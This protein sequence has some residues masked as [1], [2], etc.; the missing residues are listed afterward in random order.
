MIF[1]P[2][3][4]MTERTRVFTRVMPSW[5]V[6]GRRMKIVSYSRCVPGSSLIDKAIAQSSSRVSKPSNTCR[7]RGDRPGQNRLGS[8]LIL[9]E[10]I[11]GALDAAVEDRLDG[12]GGV[13]DQ[14]RH[15]LLLGLVE[16]AQHVA[17]DVLLAAAGTADAAADAQVVGADGAR[18][19]AQPVVA[20]VAAAG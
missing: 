11:H 17:D 3:W 14:L 9:V 10:L 8:R 5:F 15:E 20:A 16:G 6:S 12:V 18:D 7:G 2:I 19:G 13:A 4:S 1:P